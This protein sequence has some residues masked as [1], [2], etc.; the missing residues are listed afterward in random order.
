VQVGGV[1]K[2]PIVGT[3]TLTY[4]PEPGTAALLGAGAL[5]LAAV[6]RRMRA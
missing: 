1:G 3:L 5:G 2:F 4:V 6:A